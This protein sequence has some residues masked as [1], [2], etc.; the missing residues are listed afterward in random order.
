MIL[1]QILAVLATLAVAVV[2]VGTTVVIAIFIFD[3]VK[4]IAETED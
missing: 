2:V 1:L 4:A 3:V